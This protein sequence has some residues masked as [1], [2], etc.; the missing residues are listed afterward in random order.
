V[1]TAK[2]ASIEFALHWQSAQ[3][4]RTDR[5]CFEKINF[6]R[7]FFPGALSDRLAGLAPGE[8][9]SESF[10]AGELVGGYDLHLVHRVR[11]EQFNLRFNMRAN[12]PSPTRSMPFGVGPTD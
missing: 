4:K 2:Q 6:W 1:V 12:F 8:S 11:P 10:A 3:A 9:A 7:D 5:L